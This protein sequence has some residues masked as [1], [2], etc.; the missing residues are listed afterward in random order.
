MLY[1]N[2]QPPLCLRLD[3]RVVLQPVAKSLCR[4]EQANL[5][6]VKTLDIYD[7][8]KDLLTSEIFFFFF[9]KYG[10]TILAFPDFCAVVVVILCG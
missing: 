1:N 8:V 4:Q 9:F 5:V 10:V 7:I 2:H 6:R 3:K